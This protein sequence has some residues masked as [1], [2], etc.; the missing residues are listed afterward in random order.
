M[1]AGLIIS[2]AWHKMSGVSG[3]MSL[4]L[5]RKKPVGK[6]QILR[7]ITKLRAAADKLEEL[8]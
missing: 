6:P 4:T 3:E 8:L 5:E 1:P 7:W 2:A